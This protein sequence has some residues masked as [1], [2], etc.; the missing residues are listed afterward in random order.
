MNMN[1]LHHELQRNVPVLRVK[2]TD[3][4]ILEQPSEFYNLIIQKIF[5]SRKQIYLSSLYIGNDALSKKLVFL[6]FYSFNNF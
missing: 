6:L 4:S 3:I 1:E 5:E 2:A